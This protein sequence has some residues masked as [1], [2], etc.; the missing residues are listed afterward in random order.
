MISG[1]EDDEMVELER[2]KKRL[3]N[4]IEFQNTRINSIKERIRSFSKYPYLNQILAKENENLFNETREEAERLIKLFAIKT[5]YNNS[6]GFDSFD[7]FR[8]RYL[9]DEVSVEEYKSM[10]SQ[11][12]DELI[13]L[14]QCCEP[15]EKYKAIE[16]EKRSH[17]CEL[18]LLPGKIES[19]VTE[20]KELEDDIRKYQEILSLN[21]EIEVLENMINDEFARRLKIDELEQLARRSLEMLD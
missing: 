19:L 18:K 13:C 14:Q 15:L 11:L 12:E 20:K 3:E 16:E 9:N 21:K 6:E 17:L 1:N 8:K 7:N 5:K 4:F 2:E 10:C